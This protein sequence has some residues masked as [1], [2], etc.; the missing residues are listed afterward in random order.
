LKAFATQFDDAVEANL[1]E[2]FKMKLQT[3][4]TITDVDPQLPLDYNAFVALAKYQLRESKDTGGLDLPSTVNL[5][6]PAFYAASLRHLTV[7]VTAPPQGTPLFCHNESSFLFSDPFVSAHNCLLGRGALAVS[8]DPPPPPKPPAPPSSSSQPPPLPPP[9]LIPKLDMVAH[10]TPVMLQVTLKNTLPQAMNQRHLTKWFQSQHPD[11]ARVSN[12]RRLNPS[13]L[14][15][16]NHLA[17]LD[18]AGPHGRFDLPSSLVITYTPN[19]FLH[20]SLPF[21]TDGMSSYQLSLFLHLL[22]GLPMN[23][24]GTCK[25]GAPFNIFGYHQLTC[26]K[27]ASAAFHKGHDICVKAL[28]Y[29]VTRLGMG[30]V[31]TDSIMK[32]HFPHKTTKKRGDIA[33]TSHDNIQIVPSFDRLPRSEFIIDVKV[34]SMV[35]AHGDWKSHWNPARTKLLNPSL[36]QKEQGKDTKHASNYA[37]IGYGFFPF[38]LG[39]FGGIGDSAARFLQTLAFCET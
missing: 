39:S 10:L 16:A 28:S 13:L 11:V 34:C 37:K 23:E 35:S 4:T 18:I 9:V 36:A 31:D 33:V 3:Q 1:S 26:G 27:H 17:K 29:E 32:A 6:E 12:I 20:T 21:G 25:C 22:L 2:Y 14:A 19:S 5:L 38:V 8:A 7:L 30:A 15:R 24:A